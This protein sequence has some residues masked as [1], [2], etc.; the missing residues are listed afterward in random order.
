MRLTHL[1]DC[2]LTGAV[3]TTWDDCDK[4]LAAMLGSGRYRFQKTIHLLFQLCLGSN[5]WHLGVHCL[6]LRQVWSESARFPF[7]IDHDVS[8]HICL[9]SSARPSQ[10]TLKPPPHTMTPSPK[11]SRGDDARMAVAAAAGT[12]GAARASEHT[13]GSVTP[14]AYRASCVALCVRLHS[15]I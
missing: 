1:S 3:W 9:P 2:P 4:P 7:S 10:P 6:S 5:G 13:L 14:F 8:L 12:G 15:T 11:Q